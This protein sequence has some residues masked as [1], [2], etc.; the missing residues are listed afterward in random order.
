[1]AHFFLKKSCSL[2]AVVVADHFGT[3]FL[4]VEKN[5]I[6]ASNIFTFLYFAL[7]SYL[8]R[9]GTNIF[10]GNCFTRLKKK[11]NKMGAE[12]NSNYF[13]SSSG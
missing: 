10:D 1:M 12:K 3:V 6:R 13:G 9:E 7:C 4:C 11:K 8:E 2:L 5:E